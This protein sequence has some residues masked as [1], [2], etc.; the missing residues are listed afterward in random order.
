MEMSNQFTYFGE[1]L[2][3]TKDPLCSLL[4]TDRILIFGIK[5]SQNAKRIYE[6]KEKIRTCR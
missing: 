2:L 1:F 3:N 6:E 4:L 5:I